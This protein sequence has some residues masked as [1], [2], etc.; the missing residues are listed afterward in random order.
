MLLKKTKNVKQKYESLKQTNIWKKKKFVKSKIL[1]K[2]KNRWKKNIK[3][4]NKNKIFDKN[5]LIL[6]INCHQKNYQKNPENNWKNAE[7]M[8]KDL[9]I[10]QFF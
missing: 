2:Q 5:K 9:M 4:L 8:K 7:L 1:E 3:C 6:K 10:F